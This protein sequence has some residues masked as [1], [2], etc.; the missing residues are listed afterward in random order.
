MRAE[1]EIAEENAFCIL[2]TASLATALR[3]RAVVFTGPAPTLS[4]LSGVHLPAVMLATEEDR[5]LELKSIGVQGDSLPH[6]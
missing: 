4:E 3:A 1:I 5:D 6:R 2:N